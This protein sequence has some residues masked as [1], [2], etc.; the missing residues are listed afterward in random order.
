[1]SDYEYLVDE[2]KRLMHL[3]VVPSHI[4]LTM[5]RKFAESCLHELLI[6]NDA[7]VDDSYAIEKLRVSLKKNPNIDFPAQR[8]L[9]INTIQLFGNLSVHHKHETINCAE[10]WQV[11]YPALRDFTRWL[12]RDVFLICEEFES[13]EPMEIQHYA[14]YG[15]MIDEGIFRMIDNK[16]NI[17]SDELERF[18][19]FTGS[20]FNIMAPNLSAMMK[21]L[22]KFFL[23]D[24][25]L[26]PDLRELLLECMII[27]SWW[28]PYA[29][30]LAFANDQDLAKNSRFIQ[31]IEDAG[32]GDVLAEWL[33]PTGESV[34]GNLDSDEWA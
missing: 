10:S 14:E 31:A 5:T 12:F 1:M 28:A 27:T 13:F 19:N 2:Y 26:S 18:K 24:V 16:V 20:M 34:R 15:F 4:L 32:I 3:A 21:N 17:S 22:S 29:G 7:K 6:H 30:F 9:Q 8:D 33:N 25:E 11:V 23:G